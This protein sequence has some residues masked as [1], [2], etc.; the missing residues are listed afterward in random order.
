MRGRWFSENTYET[1]Y[2]LTAIIKDRSVDLVMYESVL[3]Q[4]MRWLLIAL[5]LP[6]LYLVCTATTRRDVVL[7]SWLEF[8]EFKVHHVFCLA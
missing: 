1:R 8:V 4:L 7:S 5:E 6:S 3:V 2:M